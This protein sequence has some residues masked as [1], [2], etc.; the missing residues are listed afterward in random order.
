MENKHQGINSFL[1][2][3]RF[4]AINLKCN[5]EGFEG[6]GVEMRDVGFNYY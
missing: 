2:M 3:T 5:C 1:N 6:D 4:M